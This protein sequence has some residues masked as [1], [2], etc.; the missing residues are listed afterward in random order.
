[1]SEFIQSSFLAATLCYITSL[2]FMLRR[3]IVGATFLLSVGCF[4]NALSLGV[5]YYTSFPLLPLYQGAYFVPCILGVCCIKPVFSRSG[6]PVHLLTISLLAVTALFFPNDYYLPFLQFKTLFSHLFFLFGVVGKAMFF[7]S[8]IWAVM[9]LIKSDDSGN[10]KKMSTTTMWGFFFWTL[11]IFSGAMW[12]YLG[13]GSP[14]IWDDPLLSTTMAV[15]L[16]YT[17]F[18]HLHLIPALYRPVPRSV[19]AL[20][21][22]VTMFVSTCVPELGIFRCPGGLL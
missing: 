17:L 6:H 20:L 5:R 2:A 3:H 4:C 11:S 12:S 13:W 16:Y 21:G 8:G 14:V 18:L 19:L 22:S 15:W 1:M 10:I 9:I 7:M